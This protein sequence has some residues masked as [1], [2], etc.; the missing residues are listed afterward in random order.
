MPLCAV[1]SFSQCCME[2]QP[3]SLSTKKNGSLSMRRTEGGV[4]CLQILFR[5]GRQRFERINALVV[6]ENT[7]V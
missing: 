4:I 3:D 6:Y 2:R 5:S 7:Q 1:S